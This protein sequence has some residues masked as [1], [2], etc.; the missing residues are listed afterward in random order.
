MKRNLYIV[1]SDNNKLDIPIIDEQHRAIISTINTLHYFIT[2]KKEEKVLDSV[3]II[4]NEYTKFHFLTEEE[5]MRQMDYPDL[6]DH[7]SLHRQLVGET[8]RIVEETKNFK[9]SHELLN[10]LRS[11]WMNHICIEDRK[12]SDHLKASQSEN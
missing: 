11:W 12:Y 8:Q 9:D 10:F 6:H 2:K 4:L 1:W 5:I 3:L 7:I